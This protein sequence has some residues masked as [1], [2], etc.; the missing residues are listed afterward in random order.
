MNSALN[1]Y[2]CFAIFGICCFIGLFFLIFLV[3]ETQ[4]KTAKDIDYMYS[5][6]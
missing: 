2:G 1:I 4:G 6:L 3:K 5:Q